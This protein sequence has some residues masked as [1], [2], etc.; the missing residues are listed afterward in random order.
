[1][2]HEL[3]IQGHAFRLRPVVDSDAQ[4]IV[5]LRTDKK[6]N[7]Y[8]HSTSARVNDQLDWLSAYY[9]RS[10][11]YYFAVES[12][13]G[14]TEGFISIYDVDSVDSVAE[15]GRWILRPGSLA[16]VE[17]VFL[18]Y[19]VAFELLRLRAVFCRTVLNNRSV[20]S[21]HDS[22]GVSSRRLLQGFFHIGGSATDAVEHR[23]SIENWMQIRGRMDDL[24]GAIARRILNAR[25]Q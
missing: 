8:L 2:E 22:C 6:I 11:D 18:V 25:P 14:M 13:V 19:R 15:W 16:A 17:S 4:L 20:V 7:R 9:S 21:F 5:A 1:M 24:S 23:L 3:A 12:M 10:G